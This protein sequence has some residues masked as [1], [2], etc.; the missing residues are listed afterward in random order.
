MTNTLARRSVRMPAG[1]T[2]ASR[3]LFLLSLILFF[4]ALAKSPTAAANPSA[5]AEQHS[6]SR[7]AVADFDGD[8]HPDIARVETGNFNSNKQNYSVQLDLS[9][10]GRKS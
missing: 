6:S 7:F 3:K 2:G 8:V 4:A 10:V 5:A 9:S 1:T